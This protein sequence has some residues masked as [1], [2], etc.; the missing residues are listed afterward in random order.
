MIARG[1]AWRATG[2]VA[3]VR[4][5]EVG[6]FYLLSRFRLGSLQSRPVSFLSL[7]LIHFR[8]LKKRAQKTVGR[9]LCRACRVAEDAAA[10][11]RVLDA[12]CCCCS[13]A[14]SDES[15]NKRK[16]IANGGGGGGIV[17]TDV[18]ERKTDAG[19][20]E[21]YFHCAFFFF[22]FFLYENEARFFWRSFSDLQLEKRNKADYGMLQHQ[23]NMLQDYVRTGTYWAAIHENSVSFWETKRKRNDDEGDDNEIEKSLLSH[24]QLKKKKNPR[25]T[26][27]A[28]SS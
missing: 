18:F 19:S 12:C 25:P 7:S 10:L 3:F 20:A 21:L 9:G 8:S 2:S 27:G 6:F 4:D 17:A 11:V 1:G 13:S 16:Q 23:Q 28:K 22:S 14:S 24:S 15:N 26:S 5:V